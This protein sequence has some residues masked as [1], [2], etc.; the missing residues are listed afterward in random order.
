MLNYK[1]N[2]SF[3]NHQYFPCI[4]LQYT[5]KSYLCQTLIHMDVCIYGKEL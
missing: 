2:G 3:H 1:I 5:K 4:I